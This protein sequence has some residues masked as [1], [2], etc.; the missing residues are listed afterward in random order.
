MGNVS[1]ILKQLSGEILNE[2]NNI[3]FSST[4]AYQ[5]KNRLRA[6][7]NDV[8]LFANVAKK[9]SEALNNTSNAYERTENA[10]INAVPNH[11][12]MFTIK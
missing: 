6:V 4:Q 2:V 3:S 5:I 7:E 9:M 11:T 12:G 8:S 1:G 10:I